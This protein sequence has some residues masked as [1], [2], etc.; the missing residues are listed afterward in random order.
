M[1]LVP[2]LV[3]LGFA[4]LATAILADVLETW[5]VGA[6]TS[7][8]ADYVPPAASPTLVAIER[9]RRVSQAAL[10]GAE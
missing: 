8:T 2:L 5:R 9:P 7:S 10:A 4:L 1:T 6:P 3:R